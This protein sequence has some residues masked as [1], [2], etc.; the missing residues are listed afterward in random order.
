MQTAVQRNRKRAL[1]R[2]SPLL[3]LGAAVLGL[4]LLLPAAASAQLIPP[5][6]TA[7]DYCSDRSAPRGLFVQPKPVSKLT[8]N[9]GG[10]SVGV[11]MYGTS[12]QECLRPESPSCPPSCSVDVRTVCEF[13]CQHDH[14]APYPWTVALA[15]TAGT[16]VGWSGQCQ[17]VKAAPRQHCI[18]KMDA[19]QF[20]TAHFG[21]APDAQ[22][23]SAPS[24]TAMPEPYKVNLSWSASSDQWLA[25]YVIFRDNT[26]VGRV[27]HSTT[28]YTESLMCQRTYSF[29]VEAFDW[30]GNATSSAPVSAT[31]GRCTT[32]GGGAARP[33]TIIHVKPPRATRSR[34][35]FFHFGTRGS[36][37]ATRYQCKLDRGRWRACSGVRG[38]QYRNLRKGY[39]TFYVR[40]GNRAGFDTS[41]ARHRW[42]VR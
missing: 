7:N 33:N 25:G 41:P 21:G 8:I 37:P 19:D 31:T 10:G 36:V 32:G 9:P 13:H 23:P 38:K 18:V 27:S 1:P 35:A 22:P 14:I 12:A 3:V 2:V 28:R 40:A 29:R 30:S 11:S 20:V 39:H 42:R 26:L 16:L 17:P 5:A 6:P 4:A 24:V 15:P 34:Q